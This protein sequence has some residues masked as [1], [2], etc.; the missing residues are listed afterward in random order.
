VLAI[1]SLILF[2]GLTAAVI[3]GLTA[4]W[5]RDLMLAL[6]AERR[7]WLTGWMKL[8]SVAGAGLV[9]APFALLLIAGLV[10]RKHGAQALWYAASVIGGW[11]LY[12]LAKIA[13]HRPRPHIISHL[14]QGAGWYSYPSGHSMLAPL[15]FGLG[16][17][18]WT[19]PW[20]SFRARLGA[21][22]LAILLALAIGLSRVYLGSHYP[23]DVIGGLLLGTA[24][25]ALALLWQERRGRER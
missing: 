13:V 7:P 14:A 23:T 4:T 15:V 10:L 8:L 1:V 5:D 11:A 25:S 9:E 19:A 2:A 16:V 12:A 18:A 22:A 21:L 3:T 17:I 20:R 24:W 6:A